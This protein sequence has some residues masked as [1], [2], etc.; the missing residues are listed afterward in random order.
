[1]DENRKFLIALEDGLHIEAVWYASGTLCLSTQAGCAMGCPFCASGRIG[2]QRNLTLAEL[3]EQ[4]AMCRL[5]GIEPQRLTLS[6][7]GEPLQ[8]FSVV[9]EFIT[10][11]QEQNLDVS[12]TTTGA[13]LSALERLFSSHQVAVMFSLHAGSESVYRDLL[14]AGPGLKQ[15]RERLL[16]IWPG[17]SRRQR[18]R[19]GINYLLLEG[20]NDH[21]QELASLCEWLSPFPEMTLHLLHCNAVDG[22]E[23]TSPGSE[24]C[25]GVYGQLREQGL[26]VRRANR[27]RRQSQGGCGTLVLGLGEKTGEKNKII[28]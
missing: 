26:N 18:R 12:L 23:F 20:I 2:W 16:G 6:G 7:I 25:D 24:R 1:M 11:C 27:W 22:S 9:S 14:P 15:L 17:L 5:Q 10:Y 13:P 8:N 4:V 3:H 21:D 28:G 19:M